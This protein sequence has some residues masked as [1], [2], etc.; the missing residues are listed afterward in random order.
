[1]KENFVESI[2]SIYTNGKRWIELEIEY[3][4][5]TA[6]E[7]LTVLMTALIFAFAGMLVGMLV[8]LMLAFAAAHAYQLIMAPWLSYLCTAASMILLF[9]LLFLLRRP[10]IENPISRLVSKLI[11][12]TKKSE[13]N[14]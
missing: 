14:E 12:D 1:M 7:K 9:A 4:K 2:Q 6:A 11:F 8:V 10:F 5:L 13:D 3:Y